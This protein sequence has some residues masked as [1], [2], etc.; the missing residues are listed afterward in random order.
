MNLMIVESPNKI[1]KI[2]SFLSKDWVVAA[3]VGHLMHLPDKGELNLGID[4]ET[5]MPMYEKIAS[6]KDTINNLINKAKTAE[7]VY[8][9]TDM[10][11]EGEGIADQIYKLLNKFNKNLKRITFTEITKTAVL[12]AIENTRDLDQ[13]LITAR[14]S[15]AVL[16]KMIGYILSPIFQKKANV[17][18]AGRVISPTLLLINERDEEIKNFVPHHSFKIK[19]SIDDVEFVLVDDDKSEVVFDSEIESE[20]MAINLSKEEKWEFKEEEVKEILVNAPR[21]FEMASI[22]EESFKKFKFGND[23]T[24]KL[25]QSLYEKGLITYPRTDNPNITDDQFVE[26]V[27]G[28]ITGKELSL[29]VKA[30]KIKSSKNAQEAHEGIRPTHLME[31]EEDL[32]KLNEKELKLYELI[33][34]VSILSLLPNGLNEKKTKYYISEKNKYLIKTSITKIKKDGKGFRELTGDY[35]E[36]QKEIE[37][38]NTLYFEESWSKHEII[39]KPKKP[40][41]LASIIKG[42]KKVGIGRPSTY[43]STTNS[44]INKK[45][46]LIKNDEIVITDLG[47]NKCNFINDNLQKIFNYEYTKEME[48]SLDKIATGKLSYSYIADNYKI[49]KEISEELDSLENVNVRE[50]TNIKCP[51]CGKQMIKRSSKINKS[52]SFLGC[53]DYPNCKQILNEDGT[54]PERPPETGKACEKCGKA[55]VLRKWKDSEFLGCSDYPKCKHTVNL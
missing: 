52:K 9:A 49:L 16:D 50:E 31:S 26:D 35:K 27:K 47:K 2:Q 51:S 37:M 17:P 43:A 11:R 6:K 7:V 38:N 14:N 55:M 45:Y 36:D 44:L 23:E 15:R 25:L 18:A 33:R 29:V 32:N 46:I 48:E 28:Y 21:A 8:V 1:K 39:T 22:L 40:Y 54:L 30:K 3:S 4:S 24:T 19:N 34:E 41:N 53:S 10:D 5:L 20:R 12:E 13:D 42:M